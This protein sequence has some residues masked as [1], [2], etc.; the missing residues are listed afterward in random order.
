MGMVRLLL[1][2]AVVVHHTR[3]RPALG[4]LPGDLAVSLFFIISGFYMGLVLT[5]K[6]TP[7]ASPRWWREFYASRFFR[8]YPT[9]LVMSLATL[10]FR[11]AL[12]AYLR[13]PPEGVLDVYL[14]MDPW[15]VAA[16]ALSNATMLGQDLLSLFH[17]QADGGLIFRFF[18]DPRPE[19]TLW[20]GD[21]MLLPQAWSI[22]SEVL[23][24]LMAPW[25]VRRPGLLWGLL[26]ASLGLKVALEV[27]A[28]EGASYYFFPAQCCYFLAGVLAHRYFGAVR[29]GR[30]GLL[31]LVAVL[32]ALGTFAWWANGLAVHLA[33]VAF[34]AAVPAIFAASQRWKWDRWLGEL[35][36]PIY[37]S[38]LL[39]IGVLMIA[40]K[41]TVGGPPSFAAILTLTVILSLALRLGVEAP[42]ERFRS[43]FS[44]RPVEPALP[45]A[46]P[47]GVTP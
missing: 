7:Q 40:F 45:A 25:V 10:L 30:F 41:R 4:L 21:S 19:G 43:R 16:V 22:G 28:G 17:V 18:P 35:S 46:C 13:R 8:L 29:P 15:C 5:E 44:R 38:H 47:A 9:F 23:F 36:Y 39:A 24:Y 14:R 42:F 37:L 26:L 33:P 6:Y 34:L 2:V 1:A 3:P 27:G 31:T 32:G 20:L 11:A 12:W